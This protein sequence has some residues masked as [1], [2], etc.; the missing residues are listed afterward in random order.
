MRK[1]M[2][3]IWGCLLVLLAA[4]G[5]GY[6]L[7]R[8]YALQDTIP[9]GV[10]AGKLEIGGMP[11]EEA[12]DLLDRYERML[13][14][15]T[16][17]V[18]AASSDS[19]SWTAEQFGYRAQFDGL[20]EAIA[21]LREGS[22]WERARYRYR[23]P[24]HFE[25]TESWNRD[26]FENALRQQWGWIERQEPAD[27]AREITEDDKVVYTPHL[28]GYRMDT[29]ALLDEAEAWILAGKEL[30]WPDAGGNGLSFAA[31]L[32]IVTIE[33]EVTLEELQAEGIERLIMS[34]TTDFA[35]SGEGRAHNV[36]VT[37]ETLHDWYLAPDEVFAYS[38]L[39]AR[40]ERE[41]EY[42]EA[43]VILNGKFV[44]GIGGGICQVSSTLYQ[45]VLRAGL[46][47]V[48]RRNHSL[49]VAYLPLGHDATYATGAIDF[50]F[51]N[52]TGKHL[53][54][55]TEVKDRKLTV[56]LFG[57]MPENESYEIESVTIDTV[58]PKTQTVSNPSLPAGRQ[59]IVERGKP[60]YVVET[61]RTHLRDGE[62]VSR[63]RVSRDTYRSQP[64]VIEV[65]PAAGGGAGGGAGG[66]GAGNSG[67]GAGNGR[68]SDG[69]SGSRTGDESNRNGSGSEGATPV[70]NPPLD[71]GEPEPTPIPV[72]EPVSAP[73]PQ[74][75]LLEDGLSR[76][77]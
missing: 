56:K 8:S 71:G 77:E 53:L 20:R 39:V 65:G 43:P 66:S 68:S 34:F 59:K 32:P 2:A 55:R 49:P 4:A 58:Q 30:S 60:G 22:L 50:K 47:I 76:I 19:A 16:I 12:L 27:A 45:A 61:F 41:H 23:F 10:K 64:T 70:P 21:E 6:G 24:L 75:S 63:E 74:G 73:L 28:N 13:K 35:S 17:T 38:E 25:L 57:T 40:A 18:N 29:A 14:E 42:R 52:S 7:L 48:E 36:S 72:P 46:D 1:R 37:A 67:N 69:G 9:P 44:P 15:R 26:L 11:I 33:P 51:R 31:E 3:V 54:I 5:A 62:V